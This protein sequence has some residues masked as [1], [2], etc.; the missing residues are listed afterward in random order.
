MPQL[1]MFNYLVKSLP[2]Y[3]SVLLYFIYWPEDPTFDHVVY[4]LLPIFSLVAFIIIYSLT[5]SKISK[6]AIG[7]IVGLVFSSFG[8]YYLVL[9]DVHFI[10]GTIAFAVAHIVYGITFGLKPFKPLILLIC[11]FVGLATYIYLFPGLSQI[12]ML[13]VAIYVTLIYFMAWRALSR[14]QLS[15]LTWGQVFCALGAILFLV[16]DFTIGVEK[17]RTDILVPHAKLI[18]MS[19]YYAAQFF[20]TMSVI[21]YPTKNGREKVE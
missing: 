7:I 10:Q 21:D 13:V 20:I 19:S 3:L 15:K 4:K 17:F 6:F 9:G 1:K 5:V 2:F 11:V 8:D 12:F 16:S 14:C 18:I